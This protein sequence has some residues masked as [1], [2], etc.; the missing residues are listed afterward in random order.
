[1]II[2]IIIEFH[3]KSILSNK[4]KDKNFKTYKYKI[5]KFKA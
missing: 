4:E 2:Y 5:Y 3:K 1:M